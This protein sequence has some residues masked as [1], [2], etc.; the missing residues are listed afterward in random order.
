MKT[1]EGKALA[2]AS[3]LQADG[4]APDVHHA[5][6]ASASQLP[7]V[8]YLSKQSTG[9]AAVQPPGGFLLL[10][11]TAIGDVHR[12]FVATCSYRT[13]QKNQHCRV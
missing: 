2:S 11:Q 4:T 5:Q 12:L 7:F 8:L 9:E 13:K 1:D 6:A 3:E 10:S